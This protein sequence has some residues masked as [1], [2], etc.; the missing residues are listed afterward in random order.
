[1][2][3]TVFGASDSY[4]EHE[5][6]VY[7]H[8]HYSTRFAQK[9]NGCQTAILKQFVE[10]FRNGENQHWH[11]E[12]YMIHKYWNVRLDQA[13]APSSD[14]RAADKDADEQDRTRVRRDEEQIEE[15]V[16]W[17]WRTLSGYE[18]RSATC[19]SDMLLHVSNGAYVDGVMAAK[20]FILHVDLLF[21][22]ADDLDRLLVSQT[23]KGESLKLICSVVVTDANC[24]GL[25]Y[26]REAKLL[27]KKVVAFFTLLAQSQ[28]TGVRR[29][30]VTQELLSLVTG[31]AHYLKLLIRI[32]LQ[33]SLRFERE[34]HSEDGLRLFL[35]KAD[36]LDAKLEK[37]ELNESRDITNYVH[38]TADTCPLCARPV[39]DRC[40]R[41]SEQVFHYS[42]M[43]CESCKRDL[44]QDYQNA[45]WDSRDERLLCDDCIGDA[46]YGLHGFIPVT[47]L[48]QYVHL[49]R[50]AHARLLANLRTSGALPHTSGMDLS[51]SR[52]SF[53]A[54]KISR[55]PQPRKV[56]LK[57]GS[58][59]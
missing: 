12:C 50:V 22:A 25:S 18:E 54:D 11:P 7:C 32:C 14:E 3:S 24:V 29:L 43:R 4:Y 31:L 5:G 58:S 27:C 16:L 59:N 21:N 39:E 41:H 9:C 46:S 53:G 20:K 36:S 10:I 26:S 17:I 57:L 47:R 40:F 2:C 37:D 23:S 28:D 45:N 8:Y 44:I 55:R 30:G 1:M 33:G 38:A 52:L 42:C 35:N 51:I 56:R 48:Q 49:L 13:G 6:M 34:T 19:I 15:K